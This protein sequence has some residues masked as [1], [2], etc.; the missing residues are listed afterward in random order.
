MITEI[1]ED[2]PS[3]PDAIVCSVGG[4][5]LLGGVLEGCKKNG[6]ERG[7]IVLESLHYFSDADI[8]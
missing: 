7:E 6:W 2:L 3:A 4:G 5:G 8:V 1:A